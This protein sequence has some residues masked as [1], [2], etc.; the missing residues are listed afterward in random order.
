MRKKVNIIVIAVLFLAGL[1]VL[2]YPFVANQWNSYRQSR[3]MSSYEEGVAEK[4]AAGQIDYEAEWEKAR[5]YNDNL[6]PMILPDSFAVAEAS[7]R[8]EAYMA[9]PN[10]NGDEVMGIVEI[11]KIDVELPIYHTTD[12]EVLQIGAGHLE[13]SSLPVGG[14]STHAVIS[15]HRG[16]PSAKLFTDLDQ[17]AE[18][19][20]F[21]IHIFDEVLAYQVDQILP[22]VDKDDTEAL[23]EALAIE[24]G[25]DYVTLF[26]CTPYGVNTHRLLVR[27]VRTEYN[28]EEERPETPAETVSGLLQDY[29]MFFLLGGVAVTALVIAGIRVLARKKEKKRG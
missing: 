8:D 7:D 18:G 22:M 1:S 20:E 24:E 19:D 4:E 25:K 15:A 29:Y 16:L 6:M 14:E 2:L 10:I 17:M 23:T 28:G 12:E 27:G 3:L 5:I 21:Y 11:P 9:C 26:T 13:G